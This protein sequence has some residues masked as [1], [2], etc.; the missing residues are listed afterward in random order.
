MPEAT[1]QRRTD[2]VAVKPKR[3]LAKSA[4][5]VLDSSRARGLHNP[6]LRTLSSFQAPDLHP[7][8]D[9]NRPPSPSWIHC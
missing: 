5:E 7:V 6:C 9:P 8:P 2:G 3:N 1:K 4:K